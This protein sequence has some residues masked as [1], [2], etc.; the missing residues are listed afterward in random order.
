MFKLKFLFSFAILLAL[1]IWILNHG[2]I[3]QSLKPVTVFLASIVTILLIL[4]N[5]F[6]LLR[7]VTLFQTSLPYSYTLW[8]ASGGCLVNSLGGIPIGTVAKYAFIIKKTA[9]RKRDIIFGQAYFTGLNIIFLLMI[10][11][12]AFNL[13]FSFGIILFFILGVMLCRLLGNLGIEKYVQTR[14]ISINS[15]ISLLSVLLMVLSYLIIYSGSGVDIDFNKMVTMV[16]IG[17]V[18]GFGAGA[19]SLGGL[20]EIIMGFSSQLLVGNMLYGVELSL[21]IRL[22]SIIASVPVFFLT[23]L[24]VKHQKVKI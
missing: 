6:I 9:I 2:S 3:I 22:V 13:Y 4:I 10:G 5:A 15:L 12:G 7:S 23:S 19:P 11:L 24:Y 20:Q 1:I 14:T 17:L 16:C 8:L 18:I 21:I